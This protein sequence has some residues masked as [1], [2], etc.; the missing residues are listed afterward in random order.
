MTARILAWSL[1]LAALP[2][3]GA[4]VDGKW[5]GSVDSPNGPVQINFTFKAA[6]PTLTGSSTGPDGNSVMIKN[7]KIDGSHLSFT[8]DVDFG[9]GPTTFNYTGVLAG[10]EL[11]LHTEFMG[12]PID[13]T[14]KKG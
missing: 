3:F 13:F 12:M 4:D 8:F 1:L 5:L 6:G 10:T 14:M 7:G 11:K 2:A 9:A